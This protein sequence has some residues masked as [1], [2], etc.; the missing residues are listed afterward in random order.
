MS[1]A[2]NR[3]F[4]LPVSDV[5][6]DRESLIKHYF[7]SNFSD[8]EIIYF[9]S[10]HGIPISKRHLQRMLRYYKLSRR[11]NKSPM[12]R[13]I[14]SIYNE[15]SSGPNS[16]FGYR[17]MRQKLRSKGLAVSRETVRV[18][19]KSLDPAGVERRSG[20]KLQRRV[21][22]CPGPN[23]TWRIDGYD[24]LKP[25]GFCIHGCVDG[26][27]RKIIW[28]FVGST[29]ND[30]LIIASYYLQVVKEN[31]VVPRL[32]RADRGSENSVLGGI[33]RFFRRNHVDSLAGNVSLIFN[34]P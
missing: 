19:I 33:Q 7:F 27:S 13:V 20:R 5:T 1:T 14:E 34:H 10:L 15:L 2:T 12:N 28:L 4:G 26:F 11:T 18:I 30:P 24:K 21:Y 31:R 3:V 25:F 29:N 6:R 16:S 22:R 32:V 9:L 8:S 17:Y 23:F